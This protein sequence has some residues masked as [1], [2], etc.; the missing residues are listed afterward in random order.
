MPANPLCIGLALQTSRKRPNQVFGDAGYSVVKSWKVDGTPPTT[1]RGLSLH[2]GSG[3]RRSASGAAGPRNDRTPHHRRPDR[4]LSAGGVPSASRSPCCA[5]PRQR[6]STRQRTCEALVFGRWAESASKDALLEGGPSCVATST[7]AA[8]SDFA[9]EAREHGYVDI[10]IGASDYRGDDEPGLETNG[11]RGCMELFFPQLSS[12]ATERTCAVIETAALA[13]EQDIVSMIRAAGLLVVKR[14]KSTLAPQVTDRVVMCLEGRAAIAKWLEICKSWRSTDVSSVSGMQLWGSISLLTAQRELRAQFPEGFEMQT[15]VAFFEP[16]SVKQASR[17]CRLAVDRGFAVVRRR[18]FY[19][20]VAEAECL[21]RDS[22][23][24]HGLQHRLLAGPVCV[25]ALRREQA[26]EC[27]QQMLKVPAA[28]PFGAKK[29]AAPI[30]TIRQD[31]ILNELMLAGGVHGSQSTSSAAAALGLI[32][33]DIT[34][35]GAPSVADYA[36]DVPEML[37]PRRRFDAKSPFD[38]ASLEVE[39]RHFVA[40]TAL[41][42]PQ[43]DDRPSKSDQE[44]APKEKA[45]DDGLADR[46]CSCVV[47]C[48]VDRAKCR[49]PPRKR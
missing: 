28:A 30:G 5:P 44:G 43:A 26:V 21:A 15:T 35:D 48:V 27:W 41:G 40:A 49:K 34:G 33:P 9:K 22:E 46:F 38:Q 23:D 42:V 16:L 14:Q 19:L 37:A 25:V 24:P 18:S 45:A 47:A 17:C 31:V 4:S 36:A 7:C 32:F 10:A 20:T 1:D 39:P 13:K 29:G 11:V 3:F 12:Q 6:S 2:G 8:V